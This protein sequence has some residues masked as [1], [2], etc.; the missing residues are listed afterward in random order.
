MEGA[1]STWK[2][3]FLLL[4]HAE[5]YVHTTYT[6]LDMF[7]SMSM[8]LVEVIEMEYLSQTLLDHYPLWLRATIG[9]ALHLIPTW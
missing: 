8:G 2:G 9:R 7:L 4:Q 5:K 6:R 3:V 1:E